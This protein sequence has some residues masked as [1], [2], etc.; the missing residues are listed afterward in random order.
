VAQIK[1]PNFQFHIYV[2]L[3]E[4]EH[5][6]EI[7]ETSEQCYKIKECCQKNVSKIIKYENLQIT[8][9]RVSLGNFQASSQNK[10]IMTTAI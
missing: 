2:T 7:S 5:F 6:H 4:A 9:V 3:S 8:I 1:N 10:T